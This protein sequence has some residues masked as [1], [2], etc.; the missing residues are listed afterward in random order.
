MEGC[1]PTATG[2]QL[3]NMF[4]HVSMDLQLKFTATRAEE[5]Q[6]IFK[7]NMMFIFK[8]DEHEH[9]IQCPLKKQRI[10][11]LVKNVPDPQACQP[12]NSP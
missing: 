2:V 4:V 5:R 10:L 1:P 11:T 9:V 12:Q 6:I 3:R 8:Q 7:M